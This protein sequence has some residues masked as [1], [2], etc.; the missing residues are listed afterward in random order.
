MSQFQYPP[1][2]FS[3]LRPPKKK[4]APKPVPKPKPEKPL[5]A[6]W[7]VPRP[8]EQEDEKDRYLRS[9]SIANLRAKKEIALLHKNLKKRHDT[10]LEAYRD[11]VLRILQQN[12]A[13]TDLKDSSM[14]T[15]LKRLQTVPELH[16]L[17]ARDANARAERI[18][19]QME[20]LADLYKHI[21]KMTGS[22]EKPSFEKAEDQ[23]EVLQKNQESAYNY[24]REMGEEVAIKDFPDFVSR[25]ESLRK[26]TESGELNRQKLQTIQ[27]ELQIKLQKSKANSQMLI[28]EVKRKTQDF[29]SQ[30]QYKKKQLATLQ[31][32]SELTKGER[33]QREREVE[34]HIQKIQ[35]DANNIAKQLELKASEIQ[36]L[37]EKIKKLSTTQSELEAQAQNFKKEKEKLFEKLTGE[38][39]KADA[40]EEMAKKKHN[41]ANNLRG[42]LDAVEIK[43]ARHKEEIQKLKEEKKKKKKNWAQERK[44]LKDESVFLEKEIERLKGDIPAAMSTV[45]MAEHDKEMV[46]WEN[47]VVNLQKRNQNLTK[48]I[49]DNDQTYRESL[50]K[51]GERESQY[52]GIASEFEQLVRITPQFGQASDYQSRMSNVLKT[53]GDRSQEQKD[54]YDKLFTDSAHELQAVG[55]RLLQATKMHSQVKRDLRDALEKR[56]QALSRVKQLETK[57]TPSIVEKFGLSRKLSNAETKLRQTHEKLQQISLV[58]DQLESEAVDHQAAMKRLSDDKNKVITTVEEELTK[59][60]D[61]AQ[62][63]FVAAEKHQE[64]INKQDEVI[65]ATQREFTQ[66]KNTIKE[67][68]DNTAKAVKR[69]MIIENEDLT[70]A[71]LERDWPTENQVFPHMDAIKKEM[72]N[73]RMKMV[74]L[75]KLI[76][77]EVGIERETKGKF[78]NLD[79]LN[80]PE[81]ILSIKQSIQTL[82]ET[83]RA[84]EE[85]DSDLRRAKIKLGDIITGEKRKLKKEETRPSK[86]VRVTPP[87]EVVMAE[88]P[89]EEAPEEVMDVGTEVYHAMSMKSRTAK[90]YRGQTPGWGKL[91]RIGRLI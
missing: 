90:A 63:W 54:A 64:M 80:F 10:E 33:E 1:L 49:K 22:K 34:K 78:R 71:V 5:I 67:Y 50:Q 48:D 85:C 55:G 65:K 23:L 72:E 28:A 2:D 44:R 76:Q 35:D 74:E 13:A 51:L 26:R 15:L 21:S 58:K 7:E 91:G 16:K 66:L 25:L 37:E 59:K 79:H 9:S 56:D 86:R 6:S 17:A 77:Q 36:P 75:R 30:L 70:R 81:F 68:E 27:R 39:G 20:K 8:R 32:K 29:D 84:R 61:E 47:K 3:V 31:Q 41:I 38:K 88:P 40:M 89:G 69:L 60:Q 53:I 24:L 87:V 52:L 83:R 19:I 14:D 42:A 46:E 62:K 12:N 82:K 4:E 57:G 45:P 43:Y 73:R 18:K 11:S